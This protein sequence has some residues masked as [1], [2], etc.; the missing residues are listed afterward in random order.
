MKKLI[1]LTIAV[2]FVFSTTVPASAFTTDATKILN[3][4]ADLE[5]GV[6][7]LKVM[8]NPVLRDKTTNAVVAGNTVAWS[9]EAGKIWKVANQY[10]EIGYQANLPGWGIQVFTDNM[11]GAANP[12][13][14]ETP[15]DPAGLRKD[16]PAGLIGDESDNIN[17]MTIPMAWKAFPGGEGTDG[18]PTYSNGA[19][20][21]TTTDYK[22]NYT[23]PKERVFGDPSDDDT[24]FYTELYQ[25]SPNAALPA[26]DLFGKYCFV[27]D[28]GSEKWVDLNSN[29]VVTANEIVSAWSDGADANTTVNFLGSSTCTLDA[30]G[31]FFFR[32]TAASPIYVALAAKIAAGTIKSTYSTNTLT[33]ELYHE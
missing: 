30:T 32:D 28:K 7:D 8:S 26:P 22:V 14:V 29:G 15:S 19:T 31:S 4:E 13:W 23:D 12:E 9:A 10:V 17:F 24:D 21:G 18:R 6:P 3:A 2:L 27:L 33:L 1:A 11:S 25:Y 5:T 20:F 16:T